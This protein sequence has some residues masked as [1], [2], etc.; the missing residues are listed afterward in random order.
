MTSNVAA[1][2]VAAAGVTT[3]TITITAQPGSIGVTAGSV[4]GALTP[5]ATSS[6]GSTLLYQ[7]YE[8][9]TNSNASGTPI[10]GATNRS[11]HLPISLQEGAYYYYCAISSAT[12]ATVKTQAVTVTVGA[13]TATI[14]VTSQPSGT[15]VTAG[16]ITGLC[17]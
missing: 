13:G 9:T 16:S 15:T 8:A 7:W 10:V 14:R 11:F 17:R 4:S 5:I 2:T 6:D 12:C 1:V 3:G